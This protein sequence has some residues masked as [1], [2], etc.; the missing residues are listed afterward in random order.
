MECKSKAIDSV[1]VGVIDMFFYHISTC[2]KSTASMPFS[3][4]RL[5]LLGLRTDCSIYGVQSTTGS[6]ILFVTHGNKKIL[7]ENRSGFSN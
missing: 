1:G 4:A 3:A 5:C 7:F 6:T 2:F